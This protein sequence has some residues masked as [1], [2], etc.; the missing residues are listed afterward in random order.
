MPK[1]LFS[2]PVAVVFGA[3]TSLA[4]AAFGGCAQ[5]GAVRCDPNVD[6]CASGSAGTTSTVD[7]TSTSTSTGAGGATGT[8][9]PTTGSAGRGG[10]TTGTG[11]TGS[12]GVR[13]AGAGGTGGPPPPLGD[14]SRPF[15]ERSVVYLPTWRG[16]FTTWSL[17]LPW[18][19]MTHLNLAFADP[20]GSSFSFSGNPDV[21]VQAVVDAAHVNGV[22]VLFAIGGANQGSVTVAGL[23]APGNVDA[24]VTNLV[25]YMNKMNFDGI[26]LDVEGNPVDGNYG[27]FVDKLVAKLRPNG[28]LVTAAL[29]QWYGDRV[30]ASAYA[31]F[32]YVNVMSYDHCGDWTP[33]CEHSTMDWANKDLTYFRGKNVPANKL[34]LGVPFYGYCWGT[35]C[36]MTSMTYADIIAKWPGASDWYVNGGISVSYNTPATIV[37]KTQLSRMYGGI[38]IWE[39]GQDAAGS[40]SLMTAIANNLQ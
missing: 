14:A 21:S 10:A 23:Y 27:P 29:G 8:T 5:E 19:Q 2:S 24:F 16:L 35:G 12:G 20:M 13:D 11:G 4:F 30:P 17:K 9:G 22:R 26:D 39:I 37:A 25:A 40:Q 31:A 7:T 33:P 38:M 1:G 34:V 32:D 6:V 3:L 28:K 15:K 36:P 18:S